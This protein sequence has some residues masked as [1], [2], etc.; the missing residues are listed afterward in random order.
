M[1]SRRCLAR[2]KLRGLIL[3]DMPRASWEVR[4]YSTL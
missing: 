4:K 3:L 2:E 1:A